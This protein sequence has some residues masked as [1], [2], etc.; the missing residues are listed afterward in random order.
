MPKIIVIGG[1]GHAKVVISILKRLPDYD[2]VGY[3]DKEDKGGILGIAFLGSDAILPDIKNNHPDCHAVIALG[4]TDH[5]HVQTRKNMCE[6]LDKLGFILPV[7]IS[8]TAIIN[9]DVHIEPGTTILDGA[10]VNTGTRIG[11]CAIIN[12]R[13][14]ID[15]DCRIGD[16]VHIAPGATLSGGVTVGDE[17][18]VGAGATIIHYTTITDNCIIGA[19]AVVIRDCTS[20][21]TYTGVPARLVR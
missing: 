15:H 20:E 17:S 13:C 4:S 19:G 21:G 3:V 10:V 1:G 18:F 8:P 2:I 16:Y 7:I 9:E 6:H 5:R 14:A 12:T 11:K